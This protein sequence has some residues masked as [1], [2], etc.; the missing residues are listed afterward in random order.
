MAVEEELRLCLNW[1][2]LMRLFDNLVSIDADAKVEPPVHSSLRIGLGSQGYTGCLATWTSRIR[3]DTF[4]QARGEDKPAS[5]GEQAR[6]IMESLPDEQWY[7]IALAFAGL[8]DRGAA[9]FWGGS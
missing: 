2:A 5:L 7:G 3:W 4:W 6:C 1:L 8:L 9:L